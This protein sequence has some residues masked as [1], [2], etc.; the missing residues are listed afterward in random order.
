M[1]ML[2]TMEYPHAGIA[3]AV[4]EGFE[5]QRCTDPRDILTALRVQD[6]DPVQSVH[7]S[8]LVLDTKLS[9]KEFATE[10]IDQLRK[11]L[12]VRNLELLRETSMP[13]AGVDGAAQR[14][15]YTY[16]GEATEAASLAFVRPD[17]PRICYLLSVECSSERADALLPV[18]G[19][20][21][22]SISLIA[23][24]R[25]TEIGIGKLGPAITDSRSA[26]RFAAPIGWF[27]RQTNGQL[28]VGQMDYRRSDASTASLPFPHMR[29]VVRNVDPGTDSKTSSE[30]SY[31]EGLQKIEQQ[32][33]QTEVK[34]VS[35]GPAKLADRP[36]YDHVLGLFPRSQPTSEPVSTQPAAKTPDR[37][38]EVIVI[39]QRTLCAESGGETRSYSLVLLCPCPPDRPG[40][41]RTMLEDLSKGFSMP[42]GPRTRPATQASTVPADRE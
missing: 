11:N 1:V 18:L 35:K 23:V 15:R 27:A 22:K 25:P 28:V 37:A 9:A 30:Q 8:G 4:P 40:I 42:G 6:T 38:D 29:I 26:F 41:A 17:S 14:L 19:A 10:R 13:V 39:A 12:S 33:P 3:V 21:V 20:V 7:L 2:R 32:S 24:R 34:L 5:M 36:A 31:R 16:R